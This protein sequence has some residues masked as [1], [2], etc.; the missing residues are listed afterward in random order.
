MGIALNRE[1]IIV[2]NPLNVYLD[3]D[4]AS[5]NVKFGIHSGIKKKALSQVTVGQSFAVDY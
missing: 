2:Q 5:Y 1:E 4:I 3:P